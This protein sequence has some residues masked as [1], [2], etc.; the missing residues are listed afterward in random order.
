MKVNVSIFG[1][2]AAVLGRKQIVE[3]DEGS[4]VA[5]LARRIAEK[6]GVTRQGYL[7]RYKLGGD[8][9]TVLVNG[10]NIHLLSGPATVLRD[11]DEVVI[12]P[13]VAGG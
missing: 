8:E 6:G 5:T 7:G 12:L 4:T 13:P 1:D 3:L 10:R 9:L 11:G 2:L